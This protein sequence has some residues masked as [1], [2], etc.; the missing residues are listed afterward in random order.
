MVS[1]RMDW[2]DLLAVQGTLKSLLQHPS[3]KASNVITEYVFINYHFKFKLE[4]VDLPDPE[5]EPGSSALQADTLPAELLE[6]PI[7]TL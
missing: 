7:Y 6:K 4:P 5:I 1:F 2:L 3:S